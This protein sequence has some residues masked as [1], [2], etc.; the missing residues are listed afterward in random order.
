VGVEGDAHSGEL[1]KH[2]YLV[3]KDATQPNLRQV[4]LI[5]SELFDQLADQGYQVAAGELGENITTGGVDLLAMPTGTLLRIGSDVVVEVTGLRNP[6]SQINDYQDGLMS[7]LRYRDDDGSIV[8]VGGVMGVVR[9]GGAVRA[10]D[11]IEYEQPSEPHVPLVYVANSHNPA[12]TPGNP[13]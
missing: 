11:S 6:C 7:L 9:T 10:G 1:V 8:R 13:G 5:Q 2:R 12:R 4:H 3:G